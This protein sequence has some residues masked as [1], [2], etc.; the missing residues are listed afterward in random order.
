MVK[1]HVIIEDN[2]NG[3][4]DE[5]FTMMMMMMYDDD[6]D[7]DDIMM[8]IFRFLF[9]CDRMNFVITNAIPGNLSA[10]HFNGK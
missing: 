2:G 1:T 8:M 6:C 5:I 9:L 10:I 7:D 4:D 3:D